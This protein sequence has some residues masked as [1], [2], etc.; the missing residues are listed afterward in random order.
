MS[1]YS[2]TSHTSHS[3]TNQ[4]WIVGCRDCLVD[5]Y[6]E[7]TGFFRPKHLPDPDAFPV[8]GATRFLPDPTNSCVT[9]ESTGEQFVLD[10]PRDFIDYWMS[11]GR[12]SLMWNQRH[13]TPNILVSQVDYGVTG[14]GTTTLGVFSSDVTGLV[15]AKALGADAHP[16]PVDPGFAAKDLTDWPWRC[17]CGALAPQGTARCLA[18]QQAHEAG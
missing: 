11:S 4:G 15:V 9:I 8:D 12:A 3:P 13:N 6:A 10:S 14:S 17:S 1:Y 16:Y 2:C 18:C 7:S 5:E